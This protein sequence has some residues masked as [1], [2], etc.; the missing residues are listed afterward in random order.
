MM[1]S[2]C[3]KNRYERDSLAISGYHPASGR[4]MGKQKRNCSLQQAGQVGYQQG[5][6][7]QAVTR[8]LV[9]SGGADGILLLLEHHP[10]I[11][12]GRAG[13]KENLQINPGDLRSSGIEVVDTNR[14]GNVTCHNP[15]QLVGYPILDL[16]KWVQDVH[17]Y[18]HALEEVVIRTLAYYGLRAGR[19]SR[20]TGVWLDDEKIA[21]IGVSVRQWITGHGFAFNIN[22]DLNLFSAIVPCGIQEFGVTSL[23]KTGVEVSVDEVSSKITQEFERVFCCKFE[24]V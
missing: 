4:D 11:T 5:L 21:A 14:G 7:L 17:W 6:D 2:T 9:R 8:G 20:Y 10:V 24:Q 13:G 1:E 15:G 3:Q 16:C 23:A 12:I 22:N 18:V 19:K